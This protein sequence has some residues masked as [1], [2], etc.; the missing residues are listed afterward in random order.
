MDMSHKRSVMEEPLVQVGDKINVLWP[1]NGEEG[2]PDVELTAHVTSI[3]QSTKRKDGSLFIYQLIFED[4]T[5]RKTRLANLRFNVIGGSSLRSS[6]HLSK[7]MRTSD[8]GL[9]LSVSDHHLSPQ[10]LMLGGEINVLVNH[11]RPMRKNL[12][13]QSKTQYAYGWNRY[14][15]YCAEKNLPLDAAG[16]SIS[17]QM[18][19]FLVYVITEDPVKTVTPAVANSYISAIGKT[20]MEAG[21][22][23]SMSQIRTPKFT[24]QLEAFTKAHKMMK[25]QSQEEKEHMQHI[26]HVVH[27][28]QHDHGHIH[29]SQHDDD[30]SQPVEH[31]VIEV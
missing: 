20:L 29:H 17:E 19:T 3:N 11:E 23:E 4:G 1:G 12:T 26:D 18:E 30:E 13:E 6:D 8:D 21:Q 27:Q 16:G 24:A 2:I 28:L 7:R 5:K 22:L 15:K 9:D 14:V 25:Q 10:S 31:N